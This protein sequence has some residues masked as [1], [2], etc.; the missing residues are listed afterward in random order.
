MAMNKTTKI[1]TNRTWCFALL[2]TILMI[3]SGNAM[4]QE[5][6]PLE[7][8]SIAEQQTIPVY[9]EI[10]DMDCVVVIDSI[11]LSR[12]GN[13]A[14]LYLQVAI[15]GQNLR[16]AD[17]VTVVPRLVTKTDSVDFPVV[18]LYGHWA[19]MSLLRSGEK[20][21]DSE[22]RIPGSEARTALPYSQHTAYKSWMKDAQLKLIATRTDGCGN[23]YR[24]N[25]RSL[26]E[27]RMV[28]SQREVHTESTASLL[29]FQG[30]A[31]ISFAVNKTDIRPELGNNRRELQSLNDVLDSLRHQENMDIRHLSLKGFSS[32]EGSYK[33]NEELSKGRVESLRQYLVS[34]FSIDPYS[35]STSYEAEDWIGLRDWVNKSNLPD[36]QQ[37]LAII[38]TSDDP[39]K[40]LALI[41]K[42][43]SASYKVISTEC[44]PL[45]RHTD[46]N[47][48]YSITCGENRNETKVLID[49][50]YVNT[51]NFIEEP[52]QAPVS[53]TP[54]TYTPLLALKT[55]L[56]YDLLLA[57]NI[58]AEMSFGQDSRWSIMAEYNNPW[59]RWS[60]LN[61]SYE[62]QEFGLELRKWFWPRCQGGRPF[63]CG[64]FY[65]AY[66][67]VAKYDLERNK[68]GNQGEVFSAGLTYGYSMPLAD[69]WNLELSASLGIIAGQR[70]HYNAEFD[71][72]HLI[73]K[74]TKNLFYA[75][76]TKLKIT[77]VYLLKKKEK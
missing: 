76:P 12:Q 73:Y 68:V 35:I 47:I 7:E 57:P 38:D 63:L 28:F 23:E 70:R 1:L 74:Y 11:R 36:R 62:I 3:V 66:A 60:K 51:L 25:T 32:P 16:H 75:G 45:L 67:A 34:H 20:F 46:Y 42:R 27:K 29:Q 59:W 2:L 48:D 55:N 61:Q 17:M 77:L 44:F 5:S 10:G 26:G 4:A 19:Y 22:I 8:K 15:A 54:T 40:K 41:A 6:M 56:L 30:R 43:H 50:S 24:E 21:N 13:T 64:Q 53:Y 71:S 52:L 69:R 14:G 9:G 37:I 58:E 33:H 72:T 31:Y 18:K 49:T 65:G 39:D